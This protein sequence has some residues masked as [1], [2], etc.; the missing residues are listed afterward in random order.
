LDDGDHIALL[1]LGFFNKYLPQL[2]KEGR[3]FRFEKALF[4]VETATG[5][6]YFATEAEAK[7]KRGNISRLKGIGESNTDEVKTLYINPQSRKTISLTLTN[8]IETDKLFEQLL[9]ND[10]EERKEILSV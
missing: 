10:V 4:R 3:V 7:K 2:V 1:V 6:E 9:G 5:K 8:Q